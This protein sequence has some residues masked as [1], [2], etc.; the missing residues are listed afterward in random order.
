MS[1]GK[2]G[3]KARSA[4]AATPIRPAA[5]Q[6]GWSRGDPGWLGEFAKLIMGVILAVGLFYAGTAYLRQLEVQRDAS[7]GQ[8]PHDAPLGKLRASNSEFAAALRASC[9]IPQAGSQIGLSGSFRQKAAY[10]FARELRDYVYFLQCAMRE[11]RQR[12]CVADE[13]KQLVEQLTAF[14][15]LKAKFYYWRDQAPASQFDLVQE[16]LMASDKDAERMKLVDAVLDNVVKD[17]L[18][19]LILAGYFIPEREFAGF[20]GPVIPDEFKGQLIEPIPGRDPCN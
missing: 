3:V 11:Q 10:V 13:R 14:A 18:N 17:S 1:F 4:P 5:S 6:S 8:E 12:F 2:R 7:F 16:R 9:Q 15:E 19:D 20:F